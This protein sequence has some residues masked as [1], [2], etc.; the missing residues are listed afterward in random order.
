[1]GRPASGYKLADGTSC[2]GTTTIIEEW[3]AVP[4]W[5]DL[6]EVSSLGRVRRIARTFAGIMTPRREGKP[7]RYYYKVGF[8]RP[9]AKRQDWK[10]HRLV[11]IIF[12]G[13]PPAGRTQVNHKDGDSRN[14]A[15]SNLEWVSALENVRH[16]RD[17][18]KTL[19]VRAEH[20]MAKLTESDVADIRYLDRILSRAEI[21]RRFGVGSTQ[22]SRI[23]K[24][25]RWKEQSNGA[26]SAGL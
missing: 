25:S 20:P 2:P 4:G 9:G 17:V 21:A 16:A 24:G 7:G 12:I 11:A 22:V 6:Y 1:M 10:I 14:N 13:E 15:V 8:R 18:T 5:E 26:T 3:R 23:I 19:R